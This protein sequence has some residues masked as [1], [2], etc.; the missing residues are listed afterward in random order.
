VGN[1]KPQEKPRAQ[2]R[3][4]LL[5]I[6][7]FVGA[8]AVEYQLMDTRYADLRAEYE[9]MRTMD[10]FKDATFKKQLAIVQEQRQRIAEL[11]E[12]VKRLREVLSDIKGIV[13]E[14]APPEEEATP[15]PTPA[16]EKPSAAEEEEEE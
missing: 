1:D 9:S 6:F 5:V 13:I 11:E 3:A 15:T 16:K 8:L 12:E 4:W 14:T 7:V 2:T 10:A